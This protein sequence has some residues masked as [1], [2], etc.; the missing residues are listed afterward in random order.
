MKKLVFVILSAAVAA[1]IAAA[2]AC[3]TLRMLGTERPGLISLIL[4][5]GVGA[6]SGAWFASRFWDDRKAVRQRA[7]HNAE[8]VA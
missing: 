5:A 3:V 6:L 1:S 7:V 2:T 4:L 8:D